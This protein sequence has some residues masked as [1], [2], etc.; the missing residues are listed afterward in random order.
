MAGTIEALDHKDVNIS[1]HL[2]F[3]VNR[4]SKYILGV[5]QLGAN[6]RW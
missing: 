4:M 1:N 6:G 3:R 2:L 5:E